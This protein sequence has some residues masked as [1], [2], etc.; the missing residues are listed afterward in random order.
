MMTASSLLAALV[1]VTCAALLPF[2][3]AQSKKPL[4]GTGATLCAEYV[5]TLSMSTVL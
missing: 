4:S 3:A 2:S 5:V 1:V